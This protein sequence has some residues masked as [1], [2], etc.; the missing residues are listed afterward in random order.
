MHSAL[1]KT[2]DAGASQF[3]KTAVETV[4]EDLPM[5]ARYIID[6]RSIMHAANVKGTI[7]LD[8]RYRKRSDS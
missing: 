2:L 4:I 6:L 5:P 3:D 8:P 7:R 1:Q